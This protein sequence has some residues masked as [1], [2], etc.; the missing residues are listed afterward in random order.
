MCKNELI[1]LFAHQNNLLFMSN[2][3]RFRIRIKV[4][5]WTARWKRESRV[6]LFGNIDGQSI[7][8]K[9]CKIIK[10]KKK[11]KN[12]KNLGKERYRKYHYPVKSLPQRILNKIFLTFPPKIFFLGTKKHKKIIIFISWTNILFFPRTEIIVLDLFLFLQ[13]REASTQFFLV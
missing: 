10:N 2:S 6:N 12:K 3:K 13:G 9:K 4:G 7:S 1:N 8:S 11:I 5:L